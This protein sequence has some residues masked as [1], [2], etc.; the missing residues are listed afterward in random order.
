MSSS[1]EDAQPVLIA[2][3]HIAANQ[4]TK[5]VRMLPSVIGGPG[6]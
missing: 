4:R 3:A 2:A 6:P 1:M 5:R